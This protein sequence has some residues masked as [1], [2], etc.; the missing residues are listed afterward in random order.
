MISAH[1]F[2][3][4]QSPTSNN[5][6][7]LVLYVDRF[8]YQLIIR[9]S[10][11]WAGSCRFYNY[12]LYWLAVACPRFLTNF[13]FLSPEFLRIEEDVNGML[14]AT[15][16]ASTCSMYTTSNVS[17]K[18]EAVSD[19]SQQQKCCRGRSHRGLLA[20]QSEGDQV[21]FY[22]GCFRFV[23]KIDKSAHKSAHF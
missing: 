9:R 1:Q 18:E 6:R 11:S 14:P 22:H 21:R 8:S 20:D 7:H 17:T 16:T 10:R 12:S 4:K 19:Y 5:V 13:Y 15:S 23:W 3:L 2:A